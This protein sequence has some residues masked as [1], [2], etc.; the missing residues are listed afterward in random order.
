[1]VILIRRK[2]DTVKWRVVNFLILRNYGGTNQQIYER[3]SMKSI[4]A[5]IAALTFAC[6]MC[7]AQAQQ[8]EISQAS[9][10]VT[11]GSVV[12]VLGSMSAVAASTAV[13]VESV[14]KTGDSVVIV[15]KGA[16]EGAKASIKLSGQAVKGASV[17]VGNAVTVSTIASGYVLVSA[18]QVIAFVPNEVGKALLH[19]SPSSRG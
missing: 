2:S 19:H 6:A 12:V 13:V 10:L 5:R 4:Y 9:E 11:G 15:L 17:A 3:N 1:M 16:S 8:S 14:E 18:G 7:S